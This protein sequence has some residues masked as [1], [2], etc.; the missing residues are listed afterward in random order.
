MHFGKSPQHKAPR[1]GHSFQRS[2][3]IADITTFPQRSA[4][5]CSTTIASWPNTAQSRAIERGRPVDRML[6]GVRSVVIIFSLGGSRPVREEDR[7]IVI[8]LVTIAVLSVASFTVAFLL[9]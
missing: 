2:M 7:L 6:F 8:V 5:S 9:H 1:W 4:F 3:A